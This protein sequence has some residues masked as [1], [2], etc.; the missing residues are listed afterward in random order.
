MSDHNGTPSPGP[1]N[2]P[3]DP[4][5]IGIKIKDQNEAEVFFKIKRTTKFGKII[6][7]YCDR[8][9]V[10]PKT[11]RFLLDGHRIQDG[12]TPESLDMEDG[13][14]VDAMLEQIGGDATPEH[15]A[16][17]VEAKPAAGKLDIKVKDQYNNEVFFKIKATT[18]LGK[19]MEAYCQRQGIERKSRRFLFE[20]TRIQQDHTPA[21]LEMEDG[22][23]I[24]V[25][26]EQE[27]GRSADDCPITYLSPQDVDSA[28]HLKVRTRDEHEN[29][30]FI[31][32][33]RD[34]P[35]EKDLQT[36]FDAT[37]KLFRDHKFVFHTPD[38]D[39]T[40]SVRSADFHDGGTILAFPSSR[41]ELSVS[42]QST[43]RLWFI[44]ERAT[45]L[46]RVIE[47]WCKR[48]EKTLSAVCFFLNGAV[49]MENDT[50]AILGMRNNE[51]LNMVEAEPSNPKE[52]ITVMGSDSTKYRG[53]LNVSII[54][55]GISLYF[56]VNPTTRLG[57]LRMAW[58]EGNNIR[59]HSSWRL[60][61][62]GW[63]VQD[64]DTPASL[65]IEDGDVLEA[66]PE[67]L[68]GGDEPED[69]E[70]KPESL[71]LKVRMDGGGEVTFNV[72]TTT[73]LSKLM[74]AYAKQQGQEVK[75]LKFFTPD[76]KR[77]LV[78]HTPAELELEDGDMIDV[79]L[80]QL[81]GV[82]RPEEGPSQFGSAIC[83]THIDREIL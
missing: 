52:A 17:A 53:S 63:R 74:D 62:E 65:D 66:H 76:G 21:S 71:K 3:A 54:W 22:D 28:T 69:H 64:N 39:M 9:E 50:P 27:G 48:N 79:F 51:I 80:H 11:L 57:K 41:I 24:D 16:D 47:V 31:R 35:P 6:R 12:D 59:D 4:A 32:A 19:V 60:L 82:I 14:M 33:N 23:C 18:Q 40:Q 37:K 29:V 56:K 13:D 25:F 36:W 44:L 30:L 2:K 81:G 42:S 83:G 34:L 26:V 8:Q 15:Q 68:G 38:F 43:P 72:K 77:V 5:H 49:V 10:D 58:C 61:F 46:R 73:K 20:G 1:S 70:P 7:A 75:Y 45:R 78:D 55:N 67:Q